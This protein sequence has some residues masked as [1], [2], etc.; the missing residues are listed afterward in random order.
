M[1]LKPEHRPSLATLSN[2]PNA[3]QLI[4]TSDEEV[5]KLSKAIDPSKASGPDE[6]PGRLLKVC[7]NEITPFLTGLINMS[8]RLDQFPK[9]WKC[10]NIVPIFKKGNSEN[11][12][13]YR[14]ISLLSLVS[15]IA[16][17]CVY[18]KLLLFVENK[19]YI[20]MVFDMGN[21]TD[22]IFLDFTKAF[23]SVYHTCVLF[24]NLAPLV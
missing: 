22:C 2:P 5:F 23:D 19:I 10:A 18:D 1:Y 21:Q 6:L 11:V 17:R 16:E 20:H 14:P 12:S 9:G 13:N 7:T 24:T 4:Q 3:L 15:K 8:L